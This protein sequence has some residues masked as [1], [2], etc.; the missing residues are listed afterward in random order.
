MWM[1]KTTKT[2]KVTLIVPMLLLLLL[3]MIKFLGKNLI[4]IIEHG[5]DG[6]YAAWTLCYQEDSIDDVR[7]LKPMGLNEDLTQIKEYVECEKV[8][9]KLCSLQ[10]IKK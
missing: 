6:F 9:R 7:I 8:Q 5:G 10:L 4:K 3:K 2:Q 1:D